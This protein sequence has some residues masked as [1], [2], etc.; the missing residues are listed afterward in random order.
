M[1]SCTTRARQ[2]RKLLWRSLHGVSPLRCCKVNEEACL[3]L[4]DVADAACNGS[5]GAALTEKTQAGTPV[6]PLQIYVYR[7]LDAAM[8]ELLAEQAADAFLHTGSVR[9]QFLAEVALH[10]SLLSSCVARTRPTSIQCAARVWTLLYARCPIQSSR[11]S[12][13]MLSCRYF[14]I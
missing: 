2:T 12:S 10:R 7:C 4:R 9:N 14:T 1:A 3:T 11:G 8:S 5:N 13:R 6:A